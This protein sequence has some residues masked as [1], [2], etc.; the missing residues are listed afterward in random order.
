[1][2]A[3]VNTYNSYY[4]DVAPGSRFG[5]TGMER[6]ARGA[7]RL[8]AISALLLGGA[9]AAC[10]QTETVLYSFA[11]TPDGTETLLYA[12]GT[13]KRGGQPFAG[14]IRGTGGQLYGTAYKGGKYGYGTV[15]ELR[16]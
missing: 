5:A 11:N 10:A 9:H 15:F 3:T 14:L 4:K 13:G 1:M 8:A 7:L 6:A 16:K 12:F 2:N